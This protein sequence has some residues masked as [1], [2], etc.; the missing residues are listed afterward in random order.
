MSILDEIKLPKGSPKEELE[1]LSKD[2]LRPMFS[3]DLFEFRPEEYRDKGLDIAIEL[4]YK[5]SNTNFRFLVQLKATETKDPNVDGSYSWQIE[6]SNIQYLLN[7]GLPAYYI[8]YVKQKDTFYY[9]Q[10][11]DFIKEISKKNT[12]WNDQ[13][14]HILRTSQILNK[15]SV[16]KIYEEVRK[17]CEKTREVTEKLHLT[18][19]EDINKK[20][21]ITSEYQITDETSIVELIENIGLTIINEGKSKDIILLNE[22]ISGDI[23]SP[24]YNLTVGIAAY[25]TSNLFDSLAFFQKANRRKDELPN[26]LIE[27]LKYIDTLVKYSIG[28]ITHDEYSEIINSLKQ[29][30]HLKY[31]IKIEQAKENY[32]N[33]FNNSGFEEFKKELFTIIDNNDIDSNIRFI[34]GCEYLLLWGYKIN[35]ENFQSIAIIN[36]LEIQQGPNKKLRIEGA[37]NW[38]IQNIQWENFYKQLNKEI[39]EQKDMF[40]F[41]MCK[42]NEVKVRYELI[43]YTSLVKFEKTI[44]DFPDSTHIDN[45]EQ[46]DQMIR[47][48]DI[49]S[50]NYKGLYHIENIISTLSTKYEILT[51]AKK[52]EDARQVIDEIKSLIDFHNL[53]EQKQKLEFLLNG[54]TI[55]DKVKHL[56][57]NTIGKSKSEKNEY[58]I[59]VREMKEY[60]ELEKKK[61]NT[62]IETV[63]VQLFPIGHFSIPVEKID[64]FYEILNIDSYKLTKNLNFFFENGII[65]ILN[66]LNENITQEGYVNGNADDKGIESWRRIRKIREYLFREKFRRNEIEHRL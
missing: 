59:L 43:V 3:I 20:V 1:Q 40:A 60:D 45:S 48:L 10:I 56:I 42:L 9:R 33:S 41:N 51:F 13:N 14:S 64:R 8:C 58:D 16:S 39:V 22:K 15:D 29:S 52:E 17:K 38:L 21:S 61:E 12:N 5:G 32:I 25:N 31:Y 28:F 63:T 6:T 19:K 35:L 46:L 7:G 37:R 18:R 30:G 53:K 47:N 11:N 66:I 62:W 57:A 24:L 27:H 23:T 65:P 55:E 54:G 2:K 4:K 36:A 44:P 26:D 49:I 50:S 34:A